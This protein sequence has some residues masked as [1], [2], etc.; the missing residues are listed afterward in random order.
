MA[1]NIE[2]LLLE[3]VENLGIVGDIVKV[4]PGYARNYL[5]P[6]GM[7]ESP[8]PKKIES[9]KELRAQAQAELAATRAAREALL[10]RM[11]SVKITVKRSCNDQGVLYGSVTQRDIADALAEAGYGVDV[12]AVRLS[13]SIH[14]VGEY[15]VPVQFERDLRTEVG[16]TV[17]ADRTI[18]EERV[19]MEFDNEGNLVTPE[20]KAR[21]ERR[22]RRE[23]GEGEV[24]A[25]ETES[26]PRSEK[27]G[28]PGKREKRGHAEEAGGARPPRAAK[29]TK[30]AAK[31]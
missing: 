24:D 4:K 27:T 15:V 7:A 2:L 26:R 31:A 5:L 21:A 17:E 22:A 11:K 16:I 29:A 9:L 25:I 19:E 12:R 1:R 30:T 14:R 18:A 8:T 13:Q 6:H 23:R 28:K 20:R 10:E 3:N